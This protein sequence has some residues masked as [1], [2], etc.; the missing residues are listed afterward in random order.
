MSDVSI[1]KIVTSGPKFASE[2]AQS[3]ITKQKNRVR[4]K[5]AA[6]VASNSAGVETPS[7]IERLKTEFRHQKTPRP[8]H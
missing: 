7:K 6:K 1:E 8:D 4:V 5:L 2:D 3:P